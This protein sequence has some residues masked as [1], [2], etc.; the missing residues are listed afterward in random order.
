MIYLHFPQNSYEKTC[1]LLFCKSY[2]IF[3]CHYH[4]HDHLYELLR[5]EFIRASWSTQEPL[6]KETERSHV[7]T[8]KALFL[9]VNNRAK[10][11]LLII[12]VFYPLSREYE[13]PWHLQPEVSIIKLSLDVTGA[14]SEPL[15]AHRT[16]SGNEMWMITHSSFIITTNSYPDCVT[17]LKIR[18]I[19]KSL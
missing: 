8:L 14:F 3:P 6:S 1:R 11:N 10:I 2:F 7:L 18:S 5:E 9:L 19:G 12:Q 15:F 13:S 16:G 17:K 4:F